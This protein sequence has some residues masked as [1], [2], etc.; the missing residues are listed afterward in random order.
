MILR[1]ITAMSASHILVNGLAFLTIPILIRIYGTEAYAI[2][3]FYIVFQ[4]WLIMFDIGFSPTVVRYLS[5]LLKKHRNDLNIERDIIRFSSLYRNIF[6][7]ISLIIFIIFSSYFFST[8]YFINSSSQGT[9]YITFMIPIIASLRFYTTIE[10]AIYRASENFIIL[11][12]LN[13][14]FAI[15]RYIFIIPII[16]Y[17]NDL[18]LYFIYQLILALIE[19]FA[20]KNLHSE[21]LKKHIIN[22]LDDLRLLKENANFITLSA[23]AGLFWLA[24]VSVDKL[25]LFGNISN[26]IYTS[27]SIISQLAGICLVIMAPLSGVLQPRVVD[28]YLN[29]DKDELSKFLLNV[30]KFLL[31]TLIG[32]LF[33]LLLFFPAIFPLWSNQDFN[34]IY[35][36]VFSFLL[37]GFIFA[38]HGLI[39]Y[40][41]QF[42]IGDVKIHSISNIVCSLIF[43]PIIYFLAKNQDIQNIARL[44]FFAM[45]FLSLCGFWG[46]V[47]LL[48]LKDALLIYIPSWLL[49]LLVYFLTSN[50]VHYLFTSTKTFIDALTAISIN[51]IPIS[52]IIFAFITVLLLETY[53]NYKKYKTNYR[54]GVDD[55]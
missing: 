18:N 8:N 12:K 24:T 49:I 11:A 55:T 53:F 54:A 16:Y 1:N 10:K 21:L 31:P 26:E 14:I 51:I 37:I 7:F 15:A 29:R 52:I 50:L 38:A 28:I 3:A 43:I 20:Y 41:V 39:G 34:F 30:N 22:R 33:F 48:N 9:L 42:A 44:W 13:L 2:I 4:T 27:Y 25:F 5:E 40:M 47:S 19:C 32:L 6:R 17:F 35:F 23:L 36:Q 45:S 46:Y